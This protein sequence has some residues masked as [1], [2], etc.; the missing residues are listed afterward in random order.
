MT[1]HPVTGTV[2]QAAMRA[3]MPADMPEVSRLHERVFGPGRYARTAYRVREGAPKG[4]PLLSQYCRCV[5]VGPRLLGSLNM[6]KVSI[7]GT[8][9]ALLLG[10]VA[11]DPEF[12]NQGFGRS[13]INDAIDAARK[14][15]V[16]LMLLVG[17]APYYARMGFVAV[18]TG[19]I[20]L[21]GPVNPARLLAIELQPGVLDSYRGKVTAR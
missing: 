9:D 1:I 13:M 11:V 18:P 7:G 21:P 16:K 15:G 17:D 5:A 14:D 12:A 10:P 19:Q 4:T 2:T 3:L 6:T 20:T 8:G